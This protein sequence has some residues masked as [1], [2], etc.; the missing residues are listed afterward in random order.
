MAKPHFDEHVFDPA[1]AEIELNEF[2]TLLDTNTDLAERKQV[3]ANFAKWPNL[4]AMFGYYHGRIQAADRIRREFRI[5]SYFRTDLTVKRSATDAI[6][7]VEFE[8]ASTRD[9]F[10]NSNRGVDTWARPFE[11]GFSQ[12]VD[13]AW[14]L[15]TYRTAPDFV[16]AFGSARPNIVGV[17]VIGRSTSISDGVPKD[18]WEWRRNKVNVDGFKVSLVTFDELY[19]DFSIYLAVR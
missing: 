9:I 12:V 4:C 16:E 17:L 2:K 5:S 1:Q 14:A 10:E 19:D 11:K 18:R 7:V 13:W 15:D 3:L 6:C 8:G